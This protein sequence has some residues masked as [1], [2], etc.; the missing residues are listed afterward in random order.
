MIPVVGK[1]FACGEPLY[2]RQ[3]PCPKCGY[4]FTV[5]DNRYCPNNKFGLCSIIEIPCTYGINWQTCPTKNKIDQ[6]SR[7]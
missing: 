4:K 6:E 7:F 5:D 1:C 2:N 3:L